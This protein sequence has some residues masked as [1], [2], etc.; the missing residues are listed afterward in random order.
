MPSSR[1]SPFFRF[2]LSIVLMSPAANAQV[3]A[4]GSRTNNGYNP[5]ST[6]T[7]PSSTSPAL[8]TYNPS[9]PGTGGVTSPS[10][11]GLC[12]ADPKINFTADGFGRVLFGGTK[13]SVYSFQTAPFQTCYTVSNAGGDLK[14]FIP[15]KSGEEFSAFITHMPRGVSVSSCA[16]PTWTTGAWTYSGACGSVTGSR[17]VSCQTITCQGGTTARTEMASESM[18]ANLTRPESSTQATLAACP[19][20]VAGACGS[21]NGV[22]TASAPA[23]NLCSAGTASVIAGSGPW[24]WTCA[25]ANGGATDTCSATKAAVVR[26]LDSVAYHPCKNTSCAT[27]DLTCD[28]GTYITRTGHGQ[29]WPASGGALLSW[30]GAITDICEPDA[31]CTAAS[32]KPSVP[33]GPPT[34]DIWVFN[35]VSS[36]LRCDA[37]DEPSNA[38]GGTS[39]SYCPPGYAVVSGVTSSCLG[40]PVHQC[41]QIPQNTSACPAGT[42]CVCVGKS[43]GESCSE[44]N[45]FPLGRTESATCNMQT[46]GPSGSRACR[47]YV[48]F[49]QP[50]GTIAIISNI[51]NSGLCK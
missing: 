5:T 44:L 14:Y 45:S 49:C 31:S 20:V 40:K 3:S 37:S 24:N 15:A 42:P 11:S 46:Q 10:A 27:T 33:T 1:L 47:G 51:V 39:I 12:N 26:C 50:D 28:P 30:T 48:P 25:G 18:C 4:G 23:S 34:S 41:R 17:S 43:W 13:E 32:V 21:A 8:Y 7:S 6:P 19:A 22:S 29:V 16:T 38:V 36:N 35:G 9:S 2:V